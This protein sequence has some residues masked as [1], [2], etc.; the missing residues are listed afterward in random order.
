MGGHLGHGHGGA[1]RASELN[2]SRSL[3]G[4]ARRTDSDGTTSLLVP[5]SPALSILLIA[6]GAALAAW[7]TRLALTRPRPA[8]LGGMLL[9]PLGLL[10]AYGGVAWLIGPW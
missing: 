8:N 1:S 4:H 7:G 5:T 3:R 10:V 6:G 9:A 2:V